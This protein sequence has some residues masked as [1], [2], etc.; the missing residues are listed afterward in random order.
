MSR[1]LRRLAAEI[2][3]NEAARSDEGY[4]GSVDN[5][6]DMVDMYL[7]LAGRLPD[8]PDR[9]GQAWCGM[10]VYWCYNFA[11]T[12]L[13]AANPVPRAVFGGGELYTWAMHPR[14]ARSLVWEPGRPTPSL[15]P[16]DIFVVSNLSHVGMVSEASHRETF[17]SVEGNQTD[18]SHPSW[19]NQGIRIKRVNISNC[20]IIIRPGT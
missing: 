6:S 13:N 11:A 7:R 1:E 20:A 9:A 4:R 12:R 19:G 2:A 10:F 3:R 8:A 16:G 14:H 5:R 17:T 18:P 15:E